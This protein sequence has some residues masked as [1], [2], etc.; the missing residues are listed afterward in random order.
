MFTIAVP[1]LAQSACDVAATRHRK[2]RRHRG[3]RARMGPGQISLESEDLLGGVDPPDNSIGTDC[4]LTQEPRDLIP[5]LR[6]P[7]K[8]VDV[9]RRVDPPGGAIEGHGNLAQL[10]R[11]Q[12]PTLS[13]GIVRKDLLLRIDTPDR[14]GRAH[15]N[16]REGAGNLMPGSGSAH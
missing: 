4:D 7:I 16:L 13:L 2:T 11:H 9:L 8:S 3:G 5:A 1:V 10:A 12:I 15:R 6:L 14:M